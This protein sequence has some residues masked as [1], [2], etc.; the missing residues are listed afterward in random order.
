MESRSVATVIGGSGFLGRYIV[1][2]LAAASHVVR[3]A[4]RDPETAMSMRPMGRVG[5]VVPLYANVTA[6]GTLA[7][8]IPRPPSCGT[9]S[10]SG[11]RPRSSTA[12]P[13]WR[14]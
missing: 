6:D 7:R 14:W 1:K 12:S 10:G 11:R 5:Q 8:A 4:M 9:L 13:G 2:R 3:V